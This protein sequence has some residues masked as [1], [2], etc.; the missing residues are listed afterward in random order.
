LNSKNPQLIARALLTL[1]RIGEPEAAATVA[2]YLQNPDTH[3]RL[4]AAFAL[5]LIKQPGSL[6]VLQDAVPMEQDPEVRAQIYRALGRLQ[7]P[8]ALFSLETALQ[9]EKH[10][11]AQAGLSMGFCYLLLAA[12]A[13][14]W[15]VKASTL[16]T[17]TVQFKSPSP[18]GVSAA[19]ALARY[20]G[21]LSLLP[22]KELTAAIAS[23]PDAEAKAI[24]LK[25]LARYKTASTARF[26]V[27]ILQ[28]GETHNM[29]VEAASGLARQEPQDSIVKA[30]L[31]AA[32]KDMAM[33]RAASLMT[34]ATFHNLDASAQKILE[35][36]TR[37]QPSS[38]LQGKAYLALAPQLAPDKRRVLI[39]KG[40]EHPDFYVQRETIALLPQLGNEGLKILARKAAD[41]SILI[42]GAALGVL[43][44]LDKEQ[45]NDELKKVMLQQLARHDA[46]ITSSVIDAAGR[47]GWKDALPQ[48]MKAAAES[49]SLEDFSVQENLMGTLA[50]FQDPTTLPVIEKNLQHPVR[51]VVVKAAEA[52]QNVSGKTLE[53]ALPT[54]TR[55]D[56]ATP[57]LARIQKALDSEVI[58]ETEKGSVH[59]V[60][61]PDAPLT[62]TKIA[63]WVE[64]GFYNGLNF[65][66]AV[67]HWVVQ[68]GDPRGD[69]EGGEGLIRDE[70]SMTPHAPYTVGIATAGKDTGSTQMFFNLGNNTRLD[71][72][73]TVFAQVI[74]GHDVVDRLELGDRILKA[75]VQPLQ[76]H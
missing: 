43:R 26:L 53:S 75:R 1:G 17:L 41:P 70:V 33:V 44:D 24:A 5:G 69:G 71:G 28:N 27:N 34:L 13:A 9:Q 45:M 8:A 74:E 32:S 64:Q 23:A 11:D 12:D 54:N 19:W 38:W 66:R 58:L 30:L 68:G 40:L 46:V 56:E 50:A 3:I 55:V 67:P 42:A 39:L 31:A 22:E 59:M 49:W 48:L 35:E 4:N 63:Q 10:P 20:Q 29:R 65:H 73:Y 25:A 6:K 57:P 37:T 72:S 52:W 61:L 18:L 36:M 51:N 15:P 60:M 16:S 7:I 47:M 2:P 62:A 21:D 14:S 76:G